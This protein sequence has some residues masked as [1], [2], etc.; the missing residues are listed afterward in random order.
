[1]I[2][3]LN[4]QNLNE[5]VADELSEAAKRVILSGWYILGKEVFSFEEEFARFCGTKYCVGVAN[6][7][8]ALILILRAYKELG[9]LNDGDE[10][11]VPSNTYIAT[12]LSILENDLIPVLVEPEI[13]NYNLDPKLIENHITSK[14]KAII[15]VHLYGRIAPMNEINAIAKKHRL[16]IIE[17][18]AQAHGA[19][20]NGKRAGNLSDASGFSFYPGKNLGAIGDAGAITTND[21]RLAEVLRT[22]RNYGSKVKYVNEV[23]GLNSRLDEIQAAFLRVKLKY[24]DQETRDRQR[25]AQRYL[26]E[27]NNPEIVLP[28]NEATE[29]NVWHIFPVRTNDRE[30]FQA[31]LKD[32]GIQ[33]LI[34]YP[35]PPHKQGALKKYNSI[36]L[37]ITEKIHNEITSIPLSSNLT[38]ENISFIIKSLNEYKK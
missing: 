32:K 16:I 24:L 9:K 30:S 8:D 18:S 33:T 14:T 31:F 23:E 2:E 36:S 21:E 27:I 38:E 29:Q 25:I 19:E 28:Q 35:I 15:A 6:G 22:L 3:Y 20:L 5:K 1:M 13:Q 7:L 17:D 11:I 12:I 37:P 34:H 26:K 10:V 4:L